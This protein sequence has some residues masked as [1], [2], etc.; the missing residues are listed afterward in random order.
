MKYKLEGKCYIKKY[1]FRDDTDIIMIS[2]EKG[3]HYA[4]SID[5]QQQCYEDF[6][7]QHIDKNGIGVY[8]Y[9]V[10]NNGVKITIEE[11]EK[12]KHEC[13]HT[14]HG[15]KYVIKIVGDIKTYEFVISNDHNGY[16]AH[17]VKFYKGNLVWGKWL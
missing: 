17:E 11:D 10:S 5:L 15:K 14:V 6:N 4:I 8:D 13:Y 2:N 1:N 9:Q 16:Y 12:F 7:F 3:E